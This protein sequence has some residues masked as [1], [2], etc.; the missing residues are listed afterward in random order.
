MSIRR[1]LVVLLVVAALALLGVGAAALLQFQRSASMTRVLTEETVPAFLATADVVSAL[2]SFQI[3][4]VAA[5]NE[6]D[7]GIAAQLADTLAQDRLSLRAQL[8]AQR[9]KAAGDVQRGLSEQALASLDGYYDMVDQ[10]LALRRQ[11][12]QLIAQATLA[13]N[14]EPQLRELEQVLGT[15]LVEKR[16]ANEASLAAIETGRQQSVLVICGTLL[17]SLTV[18]VGLGYRL[19]R[20]ITLPLGAMVGAMVEISRDLDFTRRLSAGRNDEVGRAVLAFN[21]LIEAL[22]RS[23]GDM[24]QVIG[25]NEVVA[26]EMRQSAVTLVG[27]ASGGS[28]SSRDIQSAVKDVQIRIGQIEDDTREAG[29]ATALAGRHATENGRVIREAAGRVRALAHAVET[30]AQRVYALAS[31]SGTIAV[32][33][34]EIQAIAD[35]TNLLALN[36]AIEAARAGES[37]RGFA[38]VA[39]EVRKLAERVTAST[40]S[41]SEQVKGIDATASESTQLMQQVVDEIRQNITLTA[42]AGDAMAEIETAA[43]RVVATVDQIGRRVAVG[44]ASS[45]QIVAQVDTIDRLMHTAQT[46][47]DHTRDCAESVREISARMSAIVGRFRI[48]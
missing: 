35:Q 19:G 37:G 38:V 23:L 28:A 16:R 6:T 21:A 18:L 3:G 26:A 44:R 45:A 1:L 36:A 20:R 2:K 42:A 43:R 46:A 47:A 15:L 25:N 12:Q 5:V 10:A 17:V 31:A 39:D 11:G 34:G 7:D 8:E 41:I 29:E 14:T 30:A 24:A 27:I 22:Q 40:V 13:G 32:Q 33:L 48:A 9:E 4:V